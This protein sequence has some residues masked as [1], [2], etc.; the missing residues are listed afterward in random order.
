M[1][2][3]SPWCWARLACLSRE[4]YFHPKRYLCCAPSALCL[5]LMPA[6]LAFNQLLAASSSLEC[7]VDSLRTKVPME[8]IH[9]KRQNLPRLMMDI[10]ETSVAS[11]TLHIIASCDV[12]QENG[13]PSKYKP[14]EHQHKAYRRA[15]C[16]RIVFQGRSCARLRFVHHSLSLPL[17]SKV[18]GEVENVWRSYT[19]ER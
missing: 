13:P 8:Q 9:A 7:V 17:Q 3:I 11:K 5:G 12:Q 4:S 18:R 1:A 15:Q 14:R 19:P 6:S 16:Q 2:S 10:G